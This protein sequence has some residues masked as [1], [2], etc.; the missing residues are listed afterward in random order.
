MSTRQLYRAVDGRTG[1]QR[2][3]TRSA[4]IG[5][6][7]GTKIMVH[8]DRDQYQETYREVYNGL[9]LGKEYIRNIFLKSCS[10]NRSL[11]SA[12]CNIYSDSDL[13]RDK[14]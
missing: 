1:W 7:P 12:F 6:M 8:S 9:S 13:Y 11:V 4:F 2:I 14:D 5:L 10:H 3:M